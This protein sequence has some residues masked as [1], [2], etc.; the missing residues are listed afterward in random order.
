MEGD[1]FALRWTQPSAPFCPAPVGHNES[2]GREST[3]R[4]SVPSGAD[5]SFAIPLLELT[6]R[7]ISAASVWRAD[8]M[9]ADRQTSYMSTEIGL[10]RSPNRT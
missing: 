5:Q 6:L 9:D 3:G 1:P 2:T 4:D 8:I 10:I 7:P